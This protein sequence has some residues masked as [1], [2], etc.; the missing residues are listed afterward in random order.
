MITV[1]LIHHIGFSQ[2]FY[3]HDSIAVIKRTQ[4]FIY[5][6]NNSKWETFKNFFTDDASM[7]YPQID[8]ARRLNGKKEIEEALQ[9]EFT[10]TTI[11]APS[12]ISPKDVRL[13]INRK[14]AIVTFH[15]ESQHSLGRY[16]IIWVRRDGEWK[17]FHLHGSDLTIN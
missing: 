6:F 7:F 4:N 17:I 14:T 10:D 5:S 3:K 2:W 13:Q 12:N 8:D 16:T 1:L 9:P 15:L 11:K